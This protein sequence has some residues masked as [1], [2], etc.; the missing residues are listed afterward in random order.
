MYTKN[1]FPTNYKS[2]FG[3]AFQTKQVEL[4]G[5]IIQLQIWEISGHKDNSHLGFLLN[6][7]MCCALV[8]D[9]TNPKSLKSIEKWRSDFLE[10]LKPQNPESFPFILIGNKSDQKDERKITEI[11]IKQYCENHSNIHYFDA[12]AKD[13]INIETTF[14]EIAKLAFKRFS[15]EK[16][17]PK[18]ENENNEDNENKEEEV[19]E[20]NESESSSDTEEHKKNQKIKK[21][22]KENKK[23]REKVKKYKSECEELRNENENLKN[24]NE[25]LKEELSQITN[26]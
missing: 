8:F 14:E 22:I 3:S 20:K 11:E 26:Q 19:N 23:L 18:E 6:K 15:E 13:N 7:Y 2:T 17:Y 5:N 16:E 24:E 1:K 9:L 21:L 4:D 12:S 10:I 25:K